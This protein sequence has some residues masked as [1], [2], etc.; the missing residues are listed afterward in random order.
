MSSMA[1]TLSAATQKRAMEILKTP[2]VQGYAATE[3]LA[4]TLPIWGCGQAKRPGTVGWHLPGVDALFLDPETHEPIEINKNGLTVP[5]E[6]VVRSPSVFS[7][8]SGYFHR[9]DATKAAFITINGQSYFRMGDIAVI[10]ADG[11]LEIVDRCKGM[12]CVSGNQVLPSGIESEILRAHDMVDVVI[13]PAP[14]IDEQQLP[15]AAV[16]PR[17]NTVLTDSAVQQ[18]L[19][20]TIT[21]AVARDSRAASRS[22]TRSRATPWAKSCAMQPAPRSRPSLAWPANRQSPSRSTL[23][24]RR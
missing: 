19:A 18:T 1:A 14:V 20:K 17:P 11:C 23:C 6:I 12:F 22:S 24:R 2:V 21:D 16:V 7:E 9:P 8:T 10:H 13:V 3:T 5:G 4:L 15:C